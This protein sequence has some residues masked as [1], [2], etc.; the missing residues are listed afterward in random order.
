MSELAQSEENGSST[1]A[2][3]VCRVLVLFEDS[4]AHDE[5]MEICGRLMAQFESDLAFDFHCWRFEDIATASAER[6]REIAS[7][8]DIILFSSH[9]NDLPATVRNWLKSCVESR[10]KVEGALA[11]LF[12]NP[13]SPSASVRTLMARLKQAGHRL[14]MDFLPLVP[15]RQMA[16]MLR[17]RPHHPIVALL[18]ETLDPPSNHW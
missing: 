2:P 16:A 1:E 3:G 15:E 7:D 12:A 5:A 13:I 8:A 18:R 6:I 10:H 11:L 17:S 9:G 4:P 14:H